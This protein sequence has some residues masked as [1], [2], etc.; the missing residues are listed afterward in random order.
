[1]GEVIHA[2]FGVC[3]FHC[4]VS[5]YTVDG[6][7]YYICADP[8]LS[9]MTVNGVAVSCGAR[10]FMGF[11]N[12]AS[13]PHHTNA[14]FVTRNSGSVDVVCAVKAMRTGSFVLVCY[15]EGVERDYPHDCSRLGCID[16]VDRV[17]ASMHR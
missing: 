12:E 15:G 14:V 2:Y 8:H 17:R 4:P 7:Y 3:T 11:C 16:A 6:K 1:M 10:G 13:L 5:K 9:P